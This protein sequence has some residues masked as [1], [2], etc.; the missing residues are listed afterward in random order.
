MERRPFAI[1]IPVYNHADEIASVA[2]D[3]V[4][5]GMPVFVVDDGSTDSTY[6]RITEI[7]GITLL[8]HKENKGKGEAIISGFKAAAAVAEWAITIDADGQHHPQDC[9]NLLAALPKGKRPIVVGKREGMASAEVP[10]SS[11]FGREFSNFWV[12]ASG[13]PAITDTQSGMRLYPLPEALELPVTARRFQFE[14][15]ILV[16]ASW[17]GIPVIEAP[18][19]VTYQAGEKR[20]SHYRGFVDFMRNAATFTRLIFMRIVIPAS[21]R[22]R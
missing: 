11:R 21:R 17:K 14:V 1:I 8:R 15:E 2:R 4:A 9:A 16:K 22:A 5:L 19:R 13:G 10:W 20:I 3:A 6:K 12:R 7:P 18:V